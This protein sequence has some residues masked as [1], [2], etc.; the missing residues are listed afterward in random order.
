MYRVIQQ[1][2]NHDEHATLSS[3]GKNHVENVKALTY[4]KRQRLVRDRRL[5][6]RR[7]PSLL[8]LVLFELSALLGLLLD[9]N[10]T[11]RLRKVVWTTTTDDESDVHG[12]RHG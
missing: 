2:T 7:H 12:G 1:N 10:D 8:L 3:I 4:L 11:R 6:Q 9:G 5:L